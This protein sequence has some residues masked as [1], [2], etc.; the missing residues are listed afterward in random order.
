MQRDI[1]HRKL[2]QLPTRK[3]AHRG[4]SIQAHWPSAHRPR[5][6]CRKGICRPA[7]L[8]PHY[9][10]SRFAAHTDVD[11][12]RRPNKAAEFHLDL[13]RLTEKRTDLR[14]QLV[15]ARLPAAPDSAA[16]VME[17]VTEL[18]LANRQAAVF[19]DRHSLAAAIAQAPAKL[20]V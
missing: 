15:P 20:P 4:R 17:P 16:P 1:P 14:Q 7:S 12:A 18:P 8:N 2:E 19:A 10:D 9:P 5:D 6:V 3:A 11:G 13:A